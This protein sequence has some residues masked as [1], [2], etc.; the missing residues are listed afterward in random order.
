MYFRLEFTFPRL[1]ENNWLFVIVKRKVKVTRTVPI[2][3]QSGGSSTDLYILILEVRMG[4]VVNT[5]L[6][7]LLPKERD[8]YP[9][10]RR[11][12]RSRYRSRL[13]QKISPS[14][15]SIPGPPRR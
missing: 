2:K 7:P 14:R 8:L 1:F 4:W 13:V 5:P 10:Y 11:I 3:A 12:G 9:L 6:E 15:D